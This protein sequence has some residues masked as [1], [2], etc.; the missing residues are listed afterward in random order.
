MICRRF[1]KRRPTST[2][3]MTTTD[4]L[5][6]VAEPSLDIYAE[7]AI[8][9][10][11][12]CRSNHEDCLQ[13]ILKYHPN[14]DQITALNS[15]ATNFSI[16][17]AQIVLAREHGFDNY[18]AFSRHIGCMLDN[19][20][21]IYLFEKAADAII[22]GHCDTL[23]TLIEA[24][25]EIVHRRSSRNHQATL[26]H[27]I[28]ANG[29]ENFRHY[30]PQNA[31]EVTD[32]LLR[33]GAQ[34]D[35]TAR[36]Y[37]QYWC[38]TLNLL[39]SSIHP[40]QAGVQAELVAKLVAYGAAVN[41]IHDDCAPLFSAIFFHRQAAVGELIQCGARIDNIIAAA[42]TGDLAKVSEY[43]GPGCKLKADAGQTRIPWLGAPLAPERAVEVA[44]VLAAMHN[45]CEIVSF[46]LEKGID[47][48]VRDLRQWTALHWAAYY[49]YS[50][51]L[52]ILLARKAPLE[53]RNE[54]GG[55]VLDQTLWA[56][57]HEKL[58]PQHLSIIRLLIEAGAIIHPWWLFSTLAAPLEKQVVD[59]LKEYL[60]CN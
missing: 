35:A 46:F 18:E 54:F 58:L 4:I 10:V 36:I 60:P 6:L 5:P 42:A 41:G 3:F 24:Q 31:L 1:T 59:L 11:N 48:G 45:Q 40:A 19:T 27:Y 28:A 32:I 37:G 2:I 55:T 34:P 26:L 17:D 39:V 33:S 47:P 16:V 57:I 44:F 29:V 12:A 21:E 38:T 43:V 9:L 25:P 7:K 30:T 14:P 56:T 53:A 15:P 13:H 20:S 49:G 50:E 8:S 22:A 52:Q 23:F 51:I